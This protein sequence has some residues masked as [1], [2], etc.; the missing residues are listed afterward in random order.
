MCIAE[1]SVYS[2]LGPAYIVASYLIMFVYM[3]HLEAIEDTGFPLGLMWALSPLTFP[4]LIG[5]LFYRGLMKL[6]GVR[7]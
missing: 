1:P 7:W 2:Y 3:S 4:V 5:V 6:F